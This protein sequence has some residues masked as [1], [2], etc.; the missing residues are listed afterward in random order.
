MIKQSLPPVS[1]VTSANIEAFIK[2]D[3]VVVVAFFDVADTASNQTFTAVANSLRDDFI[4]GATSDAEL[5]KEQGVTPPGVVMYKSY[6]EGKADYD[7]PFEADAITDWTKK[8]AVPLFGEIGPESYAG[9][10][11]SGLPLAY[12]FVAD[13]GEKKHF[14]EILSPV[15]AK[16]RGKVNFGTIDAV[17]FGGHASNLNL[18]LFSAI[19]LT[20][21]EGSLAGVRHPRRGKEPKIP[22][23]PR[24]GDH[25]RKHRTLRR[26]LPRRNTAPKH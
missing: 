16:Y 25:C 5:A 17:Q 12:L 9:Y 26:R 3:K 10:M 18:Y 24:A 23:R 13:D 21:Q 20:V 22:F 8:S 14:A 1:D 15:A 19:G 2:S 11:E 6:D 4:F 7:G